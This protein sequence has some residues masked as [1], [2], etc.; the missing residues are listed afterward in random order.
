MKVLFINPYGSNWIEGM[1]DKSETAIRMAP[2][3]L[4][5]IAAYLEAQGVETAI[6]DCRGPATRAGSEDIL[7]LVDEFKPDI[8]GFTAV[9][10]SFLNANKLAEAI[11]WRFPHI[12]LVVGG[13]HV[14]ALRGAILERFPSFDMAIT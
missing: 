6:H 4:L 11:R 3:G 13:V 14:S 5:S 12:M 8:V 7:S 9:T 10:S 2:N 1:Q